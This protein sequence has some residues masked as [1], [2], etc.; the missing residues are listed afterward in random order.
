VTW[1][2][3][4]R[5]GGLVLAIALIALS[6]GAWTRLMADTPRTPTWW[7]LLASAALFGGFCGLLAAAR[8]GRDPRNYAAAIT[9]ATAIGLATY[10]FVATG[11]VPAG[12]VPWIAMYV[13]TAAGAL[14][15]AFGVW[16]AVTLGVVLGALQVWVQTTAAWQPGSLRIAEDLLFVLVCT[17][18]AS[19]A[20]EAVRSRARQVEDAEA[21]A[22]ASVAA[23]GCRA[24]AV[25]ESSR[26]D[27]M[28]HDEILA[29][30]QAA[31]TAGVPVERVREL[32]RRALEQMTRPP[33]LHGC[34]PAEVVDRLLEASMTIDRTVR[35][36]VGH[37]ARVGPVPGEVVEAFLDASGEAI[38]NAIRHA[39]SETT[40]P[41]NIGL[42][43][44]V[45][46]DRV[47]LEIH[48][49]GSG[50]HPERVPLGR[51]GLRVSVHGRMRSVGGDAQVLSRPGQG[52]V[53]RLWWTP[54]ATP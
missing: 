3:V 45:G 7:D 46:P 21:Q 18:A 11:S 43:G 16:H 51:M 26:W 50:F 19:V 9:A 14:A 38:R 17:L 47:L 25:R 33:L 35:L 32:S 1:R 37:D 52:T 42:T 29:T 48:D 23:A 12:E 27:A 15:I 20:M 54:G 49:D 44:H 2:E 4:H 6:P 24:A 8:G 22:V 36:E 30:L 31:S 28:V 39:R 34:D 41:T 53:I 13:P 40:R 5:I 10:P